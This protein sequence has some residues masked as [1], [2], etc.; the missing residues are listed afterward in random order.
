M[1]TA[2][3][4]AKNLTPSQSLRESRAGTPPPD[5][6]ELRLRAL[7]DVAPVS[8]LCLRCEPMASRKVLRACSLLRLTP[9]DNSKGA[10]LLR[11]H[12][13][14]TTRSSLMWAGFF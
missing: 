12:S 1:V 2:R 8:K 7:S 13:G 9:W 10:R 6:R 14:L 11:A 5:A 4:G 3:T